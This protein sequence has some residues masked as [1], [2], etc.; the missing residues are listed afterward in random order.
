MSKTYKIALDKLPEL[1]AQTAE[2]RNLYLPIRRGGTLNFEAWHKDAA[3]DLYGLKTA[4]TP[5]D[6]FLPQSED[7]YTIK[8]DGTNIE[9]FA[10]EFFDKPF[11]IF[12]I[13]ACDIEAIKVLDNIYLSKQPVDMFYKARRDNAV[14]ISLACNEPKNACFCHAF[15]LDAGNPGG[16][17]TTWIN[18]DNLYIQGQTDKGS[19]Y[20]EEMSGLLEAADFGDLSGLQANIR[21]T[22]QNLPYAKLPL[23]KGF[24]SEDMMAMFNSEQWGSFHRACIGCGTCTYS[25]P[26]CS[27]YDI[28]DHDGGDCKGV[29]RFRCWDSCMYPDFTL[30]AHGNNRLTQKERFRQRFMHKL[31]YHPMNYEGQFGCVGC[32]RCINK[33]PVSLNIVK[34][35]KSLAEV[36]EDANA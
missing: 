24:T 19:A 23:D 3:V 21:E 14:L 31:M 12:G 4:N 18:G 1:Y 29:T 5:K 35:I 22:A 6:L 15:G 16:D 25:C 32:G 27:C 17:V 11:A 20:V 34:I 7:L 26:T 10:R 36:K 2:N 30:M 13:K 33:C 28:K 8:M 9:V